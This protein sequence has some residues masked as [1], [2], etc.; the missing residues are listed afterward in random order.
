M[1]GRAGEPGWERAWRQRPRWPA[2]RVQ[3]RP[4]GGPHPSTP[5]DV[6]GRITPGRRQ[7]LPSSCTRAARLATRRQLTRRECPGVVLV[8]TPRRRRATSQNPLDA[9]SSPLHVARGVGEQRTGYA[10]GGAARRRWP[11]APAR[12]EGH[13]GSSGCTMGGR[14][15]GELVYG[16]AVQSS[17]VQPAMLRWMQQPRTRRCGAAETQPEGGERKPQEAA[18]SA[19]AY[20]RSGAPT[21]GLWSGRTWDVA[22]RTT[23][24]RAAPTSCGRQAA[25][26][27]GARTTE[28]T[29]QRGRPKATE[30]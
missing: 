1:R 20:E 5:R 11:A 9:P 19:A 2:R 18:A 13:D 22:D 3:R 25:S 30:A 10:P 28:R 26:R 24:R 7:L 17:S 16:C 21:E 14:P 6:V 29:R 8:R 4:R 12:N 15:D 27:D 23:L